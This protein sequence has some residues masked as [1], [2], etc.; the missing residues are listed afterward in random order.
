MSRKKII[1]VGAGQLGVLV[2]NILKK[3]KKYSI[4]GFVDTKKKLG[5]T[6]NG[7]KIIGGDDYLKKLPPKK[8]SLIICIGDVLKRKKLIT[9]L[10]KKKFKFPPIIDK[11]S[12]IGNNT[13]IGLGTIICG[14]SVILNETII[15]QFN[16]IGS[17]IDPRGERHRIPWESGGGN[18]HPRDGHPRAQ[19]DPL[20]DNDK[21]LICALSRRA[22]IPAW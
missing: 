3:D 8:F 15:G 12:F 17:A 9:N 13:K 22:H 2:S 21:R 6:V 5:K 1:L 20:G 4:A 18:D 19:S 16:I 11:N 10:S 7:I 14:H